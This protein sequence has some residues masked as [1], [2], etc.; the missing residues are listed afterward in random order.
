MTDPF[1]SPLT[2]ISADALSVNSSST[3]NRHRALGPNPGAEAE[4]EPASNSNHNTNGVSI[5]TE[6]EGGNIGKKSGSPSVSKPFPPSIPSPEQSPNPNSC[7][8]ANRGLCRS[9]KR[10]SEPLLRFEAESRSIKRR[11]N[12]RRYSDLSESKATRHRL[13]SLETTRSRSPSSK[14]RRLSDVPDLFASDQHSGY[15]VQATANVVDEDVLK[16]RGLQN[17]VERSRIREIVH[18]QNVVV[19]VLKNGLA[20]AFHRSFGL[21]PF[22]IPFAVWHC[23]DA[24]NLAFS[25]IR[26]FASALLP[27][28]EEGR[29]GAIH[30]LQRTGRVIGGLLGIQSQDF[31]NAIHSN[32]GNRTRPI[33][34]SLD[35]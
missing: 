17:F 4:P 19:G 27:Q 21:I 2:S 24:L 1:P 12:K 15:R 16:K 3:S 11:L 5:W 18:A 10:K 35:F 31:E 13:D 28:P 14:R 25:K 6:T 26:G 20:A 34:R 8:S 32:P 33:S 30:I 9:S 7:S 29:I 22:A 23:S